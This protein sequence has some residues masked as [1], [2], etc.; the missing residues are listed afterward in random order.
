MCGTNSDQIFNTLRPG[1]IITEIHQTFSHIEQTRE[2]VSW[3]NGL[4]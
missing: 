4:D 2:M 3:V 1:A